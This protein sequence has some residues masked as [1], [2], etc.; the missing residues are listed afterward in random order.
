MVCMIIHKDL[1][2]FSNTRW[3]ILDRSNQS[4]PP[5]T[6]CWGGTCINRFPPL[7]GTYETFLEPDSDPAVLL[8]SF[9]RDRVIAIWR[10][11]WKTCLDRSMRGEWEK[12]EETKEEGWRREHTNLPSSFNLSKLN[13]SITSPIK[14]FTNSISSLCFTLGSNDCCLSLL[15]CFF[16][17]E[18]RSLCILLSDLFLFDCCCEFFSES[19]VSSS[20]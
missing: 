17:Y 6:Y 8:V 15:F 5:I 14:C 13:K 10:V 1:I 7:A 2:P 20:R 3:P 16:N 18:F 19:I 11:G 4:Y 12:G 9:N